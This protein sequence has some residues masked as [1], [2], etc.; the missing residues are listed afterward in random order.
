MQADRKGIN[1][2]IN[3]YK[4]FVEAHDETCITYAFNHFIKGCVEEELSDVVIRCLDL[5]GVRG[6]DL[7]KVDFFMSNFEPGKEESLIDLCY[8]MSSIAT[9]PTSTENKMNGIIA[10]IFRYCELTGIDID[11]FIRTKMKYNRLRGYKHGG[12]KY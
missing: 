7:S 9:V 8:Y 6:I 10:F 2:D 11:F 3:G 1:P 5:A 12:K 4:E